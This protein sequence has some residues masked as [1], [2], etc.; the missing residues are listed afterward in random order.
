MTEKKN[1]PVD[2]L[3]V[4]RVKAKI[5]GNETR[6]GTLHNVTFSKLY[7]VTTEE[8]GKEKK[9][10]RESSSFSQED[11][12]GLAKAADQAFDRILALASDAE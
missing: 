8:N 10:W 11:L 4:G 3:R 7:V 2:E 1:K 9:Q 12:L 6:N 5:W